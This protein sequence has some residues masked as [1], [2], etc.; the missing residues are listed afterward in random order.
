MATG[1][2]LVEGDAGK[3]DGQSSATHAHSQNAHSNA[4]ETANRSVVRGIRSAM[5]GS[6]PNSE[7]L[8]HQAAGDL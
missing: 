5:P 2:A 1:M 7:R 4:A 6:I 8:W 3:G